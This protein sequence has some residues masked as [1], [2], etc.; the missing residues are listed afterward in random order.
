MIRFRAGMRRLVFELKMYPHVVISPGSGIWPKVW[1][2]CGIFYLIGPI[3]FYPHPVLGVHNADET[4]LL[5]ASLFM[6]RLLAPACRLPAGFDPGLVERLQFRLRVLQADLGNFYL[7]QHRHQSGFIISGKNSGSHWLKFMLN[8]ALAV[9]FDVP[10][11]SR[12]TGPSADYILGSATKPNPFSHLPHYATSHTIPSLF[13][14]CRFAF[15]F[16]PKRPI[17]VL[18]RDVGDA[19]CSNYLKWRDLYGSTI[20]EYIKG[21]PTSRR[22]IADAWWYVHFFNRWGDVMQANPGLVL[23]VRYEDLKA[24]PAQWLRQIA[25]HLGVSLTTEALASGLAFYDRESMRA[26]QDE[27]HGEAV[28]ADVA[29]RG[30]VKLSLREQ[31]ILHTL[32]ACHLRHDLGYGYET[33]GNRL[34]KMQPR[35]PSPR[36]I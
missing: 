22:Y 11:P 21:D 19:L 23:L 17:V 24:E 12:S 16:V 25:A 26:R 2:A 6:A 29:A 34:R 35:H 3:D 32:L 14:A 8:T 28:V 13:F 31:R 30:E 7:L 18:V 9:Q 27:A 5:L 33:R 10:P 15:R 4:L 1:I 20:E 36:L